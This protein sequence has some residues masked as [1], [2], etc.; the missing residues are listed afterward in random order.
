MMLIGSV[1]QNF[2]EATVGLAYLELQLEDLKTRNWSH[3]KSHLLAYLMVDNSAV[4]TGLE[5]I[6]VHSNP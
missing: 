3:L 6:S 1:G 2:R 5:K 4:A